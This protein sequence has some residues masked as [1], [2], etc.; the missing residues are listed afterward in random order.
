MFVELNWV[1]II[2]SNFRK[3]I[4][5]DDREWPFMIFWW[6]SV[7][8]LLSVFITFWNFLYHSLRLC[9]N[10]RNSSVLY[11]I[12]AE[13]LG[14]TGFPEIRILWFLFPGLFIFLGNST[15]QFFWVCKQKKRLNC[16]SFVAID[17]IDAL[18]RYLYNNNLI[19][20]QSPF[21]KTFNFWWNFEIRL[22]SNFSRD[23]IDWRGPFSGH[24]MVNFIKSYHFTS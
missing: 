12:G 18:K 1:K 13:K 16:E 15:M 6:K 19:S 14:L 21:Q 22:K 3:W 2:K 24:K 11:F 20:T 4:T 5:I 10:L 23:F 9:F 7:G 8:I 17:E